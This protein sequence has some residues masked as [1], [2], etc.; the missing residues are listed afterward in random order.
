MDPPEVM[1]PS[2]DAGL[3]SFITLAFT[4]VTYRALIADPSGKGR[5][6]SYQLLACADQS[7]LTCGN[8]WESIPLVNWTTTTATDQPDGG[9]DGGLTLSGL[10][11]GT[12]IVSFDGG[13]PLLLQVLRDDPYKGLGGLLT[14][15]VLQLVGDPVAG[16]SA[17]VEEIYAQKLMVY[18]C[19]FFPDMN[20]SASRNRN[21]TLKGF[22]L[23]AEDWPEDVIP[24]RTGAGPFHVQAD[25][26]SDLEETYA[27][28]DF[29]LQELY[30]KEAWIIDY[31]ATLGSFA[32][33]E[34]GGEDLSGNVDP[35]TTGWSPPAGA[36]EQIVEFW[37]TVRNG[38][39]G[40]SWTRRF[41]HYIP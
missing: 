3:E 10:T 2:C 32:P 5:T 36:R 38:R 30:L 8:A 1:A 26:V 35:H 37:F 15:L 17:G 16:S 41:L 23:D 25:D 14:P 18:S 7:D 39:G 13:T 27:V 34:T 12:Q 33:E 40:F 20:Q 22:T 29:N 9:F 11:P 31:Y 21:P 28:V 4:P 19:A 6:L 24:T